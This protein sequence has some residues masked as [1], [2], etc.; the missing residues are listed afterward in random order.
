[1]L[2]SLI[3]FVGNIVFILKNQEIPEDP[4]N[5]VIMRSGGIGDVLMSTPLV[6]SVRQKY[7]RA[8]ITYLVGEYSADAI[9]SNPNIDRVMTYK[10][11]IIF[12]QNKSEVNKLIQ[13]IKKE[14]FDLTFVLDK[15]WQWNLLAYFA[16]IPFRI[17]FDRKGEGFANNIS[18][19]FDGTKYELEYY[20]ELAKAA[21]IEDIP[22]EMQFYV[23]SADRR[24][25]DEVWKNNKLSK[26]KTIV[27][28]PGGAKNPGQE[29]PQKRWP[30]H[31]YGRLADELI[32]RKYQVAILGAKDDQEICKAAIRN[33]KRKT[34]VNLCG[35]LNLAQSAAFMQDARLV[36]THDSGPMHLAA[37]MRVPLVAIF[38]PT[39]PLRFAPP[40]ARVMQDTRVAPPSY[41]IYGKLSNPRGS[42]GA[43]GVDVILK[44]ALAVLKKK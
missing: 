40:S 37:A 11:E 30:P 21:E 1:M 33:M 4:K 36:I 44:E 12:R 23:N 32:A 22:R 38:G 8:K 5:I 13:R 10:D 3:C 7:P 34:T 41:D 19:P 27:L 31:H 6:K 26:N 15:A 17:G 24:K 16:K 25:A 28:I 9:K 29:L 39:D 14:K 2:R 42:I 35:K 43:I 18:I 20:R